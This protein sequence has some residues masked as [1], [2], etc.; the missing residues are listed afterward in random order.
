VATSPASSLLLASPRFALCIENPLTTNSGRNPSPN[1]K[2]GP[3]LGCLPKFAQKFPFFG[4][5]CLRDVFIK[6]VF[7]DFFFRLFLFFS[8]IFLKFLKVKMPFCPNQ[9]TR[10]G[11]RL[12]TRFGTRFRTSLGD[13]LGTFRGFEKMIQLYNLRRL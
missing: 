9:G 3:F 4:T 6:F 11:T 12:G 5:P 7:L 13:R 2:I 1:S 8:D 10:F